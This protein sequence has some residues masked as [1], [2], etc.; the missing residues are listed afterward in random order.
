VGQVVVDGGEVHAELVIGGDLALGV[1][2]VDKGLSGFAVFIPQFG[3]ELVGALE[4]GGGI[5]SDAL[6]IGGLGD[7]GGDGEADRG[8]HGV[9]LRVETALVVVGQVRVSALELLDTQ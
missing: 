2:L 1:A 4:R 3:D 7:T 6:V 5:G 9:E 8:I